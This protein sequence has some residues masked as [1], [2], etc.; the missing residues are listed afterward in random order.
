MQ[1]FVGQEIERYLITKRL[2][3]IGMVVVDKIYLNRVDPTWPL[4]FPLSP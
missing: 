3:V 2:G 4:I 1:K